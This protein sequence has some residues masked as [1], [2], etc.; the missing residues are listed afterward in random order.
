MKREL[1]TTRLRLRP[2]KEGDESW[3]AALYSDP[4]VMHFIPGGAQPPQQAWAS[5]HDLIYLDKLKLELGHWAIEEAATAKIHGWVA[6]KKLGDEIEIGYRLRKESW[7]S[8]IATEA[9]LRLLRHALDDLH[10]DRI[11]AIN[12]RGNA[13]S[14]R[15][16]TKIGLRFEK[17]Y[18]QD[19]QEWRYFAISTRNGI[20]PRR[21]SPPN[22]TG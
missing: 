6:L 8:G 16:S 18:V 15:V 4:D 9:A 20:L 21:S 3:L 17:T 5:A 10:L 11:V 22:R 2:L 1:H 13:A 14:E 7:G 12:L 19:G